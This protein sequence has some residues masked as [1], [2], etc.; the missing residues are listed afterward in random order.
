MKKKTSRVVDELFISHFAERIA[1]KAGERDEQA[2]EAYLIA[3]KRHLKVGC[4]K[5]CELLIKLTC[6]V[7]EMVVWL[8]GALL[9]YMCIIMSVATAY[10]CCIILLELFQHMRYTCLWRK[11]GTFH[12]DTRLPSLFLDAAREISLLYNDKCDHF[13]IVNMLYY[14]SSYMAYELTEAAYI[15]LKVA[16]HYFIYY[17]IF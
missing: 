16:Q 12:N 14:S 11:T 15:L 5:L 10:V 17:C 2:L 8:L 4:C 9:G 7:V 13:S 1:Q 6:K 3:K